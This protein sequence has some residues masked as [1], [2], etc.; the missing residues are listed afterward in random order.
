MQVLK[1]RKWR[2][3]GLLYL[4][5]APAQIGEA[6]FM[7]VTR[8]KAPGRV[9]ASGSEISRRAGHFKTSGKGKKKNVL[10]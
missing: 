10:K 7:L 9:G 8:Q 2:A 3:L 6:G 1:G 4:V 5:L